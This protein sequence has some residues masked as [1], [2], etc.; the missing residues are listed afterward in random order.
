MRCS[1]ARVLSLNIVKVLRENTLHASLQFFV[2]R[3]SRL[4]VAGLAR[5]SSVVQQASDRLTLTRGGHVSD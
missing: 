5:C 1:F 4:Q 2:R 3:L